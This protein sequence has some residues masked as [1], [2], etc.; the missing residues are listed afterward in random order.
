MQKM[1][2]Y[3]SN[4]LSHSAEYPRESWDKLIYETRNFVVTP[5]IGALIEG[6]VLI[7]RLRP[8]TGGNSI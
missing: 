1:C 7:I 8:I 3:C 5:T 6:W 2:P 4:I